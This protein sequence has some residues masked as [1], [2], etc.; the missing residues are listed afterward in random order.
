MH[1][2]IIAAAD[3]S[4]SLMFQGLGTGGEVEVE[5]GPDPR[6]ENL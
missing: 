3:L 2:I 4:H 1:F 5:L 6:C